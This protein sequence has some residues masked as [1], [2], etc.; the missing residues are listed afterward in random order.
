MQRAM[1]RKKVIEDLSR[2]KA[3]RQTVVL[4]A[5]LEVGDFFFDCLAYDLSLKGA[6][7][8]LDLPLKVGVD[9]DVSVNGSEI[10]SCRLAWVT[11][12][13]MGVEFSAEPEDVRRIL[14]D[15]GGKLSGSEE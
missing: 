9:V 4:K 2:R 14:G 13:F 3:I 8:K 5:K 1:S 10:I 6:K 7:L 15:L 12:G 11:E